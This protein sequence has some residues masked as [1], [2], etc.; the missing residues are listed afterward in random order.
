[1]AIAAAGSGSENTPAGVSA[2]S[3]SGRR[4]GLLGGTFD[5]PH[6]GHLA[7][8]V[9]VR[10]ALDLDE[11]LLVVAGSPWQKEGTRPISPAGDRLAMVEAAVADVPGLVVSDIEVRRAGPSYTID[12]VHELLRA[13]PGAEVYLILG[14]D[15]AALITTWERYEELVRVCHPVVVGRPGSHEELPPVAEWIRVEV[16]HLDISS[17]DLRDRFVDGRPLEFLLPAATIRVA[18]ERGLYGRTATVAAPAV[19]AQQR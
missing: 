10:H 15:A 13:I 3:H 5:P 1:M 2:R 12:T 18:H 17:T 19:G 14:A 16:P 4:I 11:V 6:Y 8:A 9:N 7:A